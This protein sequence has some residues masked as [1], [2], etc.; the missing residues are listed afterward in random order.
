M[1]IEFFM[2]IIIKNLV[3]VLLFLVALSSCGDKEVLDGQRDYALIKAMESAKNQSD[4][5]IDVEALEEHALAYEKNNEKGKC[6]IAN[7]LIG[8]KLFYEYDYD[9]SLI[10]FKK[11]E[12]NLEYCDSISSFVYGLI[13]RNISTTDT[14]LALKY[15]T[16]AWRKI[17]NII[18]Y[19]NCLILI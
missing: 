19:D 2:R 15:A 16:K 17:W 14:L 13:V 3:V 8:Y 18:I 12:Q 9:K 6:C 4:E 7:A 10:Y 5:N 11:A 1:F